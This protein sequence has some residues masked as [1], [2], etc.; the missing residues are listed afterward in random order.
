MQ[1]VSR[2]EEDQK[3]LESIGKSIDMFAEDS[4]IQS[5]SFEALKQQLSD[6]HI[7]IEAMRIANDTDIADFRVLAVRVGVEVLDGEIGR[8]SCRERV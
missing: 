3:V 2:M 8:A 5:K 1:A 4:E 7:I 6:Y